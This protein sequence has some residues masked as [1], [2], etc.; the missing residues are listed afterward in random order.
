MRISKLRC[1]LAGSLLLLTISCRSPRPEMPATSSSGTSQD[2]TPPEIQE[3]APQPTDTFPS[4]EP[5][6]LA[7]PLT[8]NP[9]DLT[10]TPVQESETGVPPGWKWVGLLD[11]GVQMVVPETW[12]DLVAL[13]DTPE[14]IARLGQRCA[15]R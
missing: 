7:S 12:V 14:T 10:L 2:A 11:D 13:L 9:D 3:S 4:L 5:I 8:N 1:L 15:W 6:P